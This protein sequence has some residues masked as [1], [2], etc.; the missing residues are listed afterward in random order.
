MITFFIWG[1]NQIMVKFAGFPPGKLRFTRI[2]NPFFTDLLPEID[3][4]NELKI[5]L[6]VFWRFDHMEGNFRYLR[7]QNLLSDETL[8]DAL[9]HNK[10][11]AVAIMQQ[12]IENMLQRGTI[13][14]AEIK[15]EDQVEHLYFLNT[16]RGQNAVKAIALGQWVPTG[17]EHFPITLKLEKPN[18]FRLYEEHIG[19]IT[20][21]ISESLQDVEQEYSPEIVE[22]AI[23]IAV[24]NNV[25]KWNYVEAILKRWKEEGKNE[26]TYQGDSEKDRKKY[27]E[28]KFSDFIK[29]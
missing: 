29:H 24:E 1:Y 3:D 5:T 22:E 21:M 16:V 18:I 10:K 8:L 4:L 20:P 9:D 26:R 23:R 6:Y 7:L 11:K 13:I 17:D 12:S 15:I 19:P 14:S 25:R 28:G 27:V 2:P